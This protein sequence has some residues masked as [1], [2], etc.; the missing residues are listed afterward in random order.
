M[1]EMIKKFRNKIMINIRGGVMSSSAQTTRVRVG[2][3][4]MMLSNFE[5]GETYMYPPTFVWAWEDLRK[6]LIGKTIIDVRPDEA[7]GVIIQCVN[8]AL[9]IYSREGEFSG[10]TVNGVEVVNRDLSV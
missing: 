4:I 7:E 5:N 6:L 1:I 9:H 2:G 8:A 10:L 3:F